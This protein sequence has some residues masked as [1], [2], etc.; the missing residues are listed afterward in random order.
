MFFTFCFS[1]S[2]TES[3][4]QFLHSKWTTS[5]HFFKKNLDSAFK[6]QKL[7]NVAREYFKRQ[8]RVGHRPSVCV[9]EQTQAL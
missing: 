7:T 5:Q 8:L 9:C 3:L 2:E 6:N 1:A 4:Y